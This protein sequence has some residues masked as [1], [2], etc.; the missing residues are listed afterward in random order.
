MGRSI[1]YLN[2]REV[3]A[4]DILPVTNQHNEADIKVVASPVL[5]CTLDLVAADELRVKPV[6]NTASPPDSPPARYAD[7][8]F[9]MPPHPLGR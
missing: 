1:W 2:E 6:L 4:I 3:E 5:P 8:E 7:T 9:D